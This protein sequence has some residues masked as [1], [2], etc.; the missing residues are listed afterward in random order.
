MEEQ[1]REL[2]QLGFLRSIRGKLLLIF[3]LLLAVALTVQ[4]TIALSS[5]KQINYEMV[6]TRLEAREG[7]CGDCG[8]PHRGPVQYDGGLESARFPARGYAELAGEG[9]QAGG[10]SWARRVL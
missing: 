8:S 4:N 7:Y 5:S 10:H 9:G 1:K 3:G 6:G 2:R